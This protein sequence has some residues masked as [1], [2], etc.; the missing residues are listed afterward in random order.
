M[1]ASKST[2]VLSSEDVRLLHAWWRASNYIGAAQIFLKDNALLRE[3]LKPEH[4]KPRLLGHWGTTPGLNFIYTHLNRLIAKHD[5]NMMYVAGPGHGGAAVLA[6][7]YMEGSFTE[8]HPEITQDE[9]GL[10][11]LMKQFSWPYGFSS[12]VDVSTPGAIHFGGELG[13]SLLHATGAV[14]DNPDLI[15]ACVVGDGESETG[16]CAA[17]W[18]GHHFLDPA[19]DG[20]VLPVL[21]LNGYKIGNPT[22]LARIPDTQREQYF[23]GLG[24]Q[25]H[26]LAGD[27]PAAMHPAMA[28]VLERMLAEIRAIQQ[29]AREGHH[30][31]H[32]K[33]PLLILRTPKGWTGPKTVD[34]KPVEDTWRSHQVPIDK[35]QTDPEH[36]KI[37]EEWLRSYR[38]E[39]LFDE[40]GRLVPE[41]LTTLPEPARRIG[42]NPH[43]NGGDLLRNL[44]LPAFAEYAVELPRPGEVK[45]SPM[46]VLGSFLRDVIVRNPETFRLMVPDELISNKLDATLEVTSR[47]WEES[48]RP[49]DMWLAEGGRV[50]EVLSEHLL[51]GW[52]EGYLLTGRHG[53]LNS[54]EAF[55]HI[56]SSMVNQHAKWLK[57]ANEIAWRT[58]V[59]SLNYLLSSH[60]WQQDH[61]GFTHQDPGFLDH[62]ANKKADI[63][64]IYLPPDAN[65]LLSVADH[66]LRSRNYINVIVAGKQE[67]LQWLTADEASKHC[68]TGLGV[69]PWAGSEQGGHLDLV[70]ACAGDVPTIEAI[71]AAQLLK[72]RAPDMK[73]RLVNVVD[74]MTLSTA[75]THPHAVSDET[76]LEIF[77][78][79][80]PVLFAFHGYPSLIHR[81]TSERPNQ[82]NF[83]VRG[84]VEEGAATTPFDMTVLNRLDRYSLAKDALR[85]AGGELASRAEV[86]SWLEAK[87]EEH[88]A[89]VKENGIDL[90]EIREW[91]LEGGES[92]Q[93][94][95]V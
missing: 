22:L 90:P 75:D 77:T 20:A 59:A 86:T 63:V 87:L 3:P 36:L 49:T 52:L 15:V 72:E 11:Q 31:E 94:G 45:K 78:A 39:E 91:S 8:R 54:Y 58:P 42:K 88:R 24:Y 34:G 30:E 32:P 83:H 4:I 56:V 70:I 61:N 55:I 1:S 40:K 5:L 29:R 95:E 73:I 43:A 74:L 81:L 48:R 46:A 51:Q 6:Q 69:W 84:Y 44:D 18:Q 9:Q 14:F 85:L 28:E 76:F 68:E 62:I 57:L 7:T 89:F 50:M 92:I 93:S 64:R 12:H 60:V 38:P 16:P 65:C 37:L 80:K 71:A 33:W 26:L 67:T 27:D 47:E 66:C 19:R 21:H 53:I 17:S 35:P 25:P 79:G 13:Y 41:L 23:V 10:T 2:T 82:A